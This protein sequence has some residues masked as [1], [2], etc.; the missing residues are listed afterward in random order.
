MTRPPEVDQLRTASFLGR[1][2]SFPPEFAYAPSGVHMVA[3]EEDIRA[4]LTI[5]FGTAAGSG[6]SARNTASTCMS[7]CS[8]L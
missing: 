5:L 8:S 4:S 2:W 6:S 7:C 3:D 1:G